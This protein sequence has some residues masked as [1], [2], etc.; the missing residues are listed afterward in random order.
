VARD[1]R[2]ALGRNERGPEPVTDEVALWYRRYH[3]MEY[4]IWDSEEEA[5]GIAAAMAVD[6]GG[7]P[8]GVQV[9]DGR[10]IP[11][12]EWEALWAARERRDRAWQERPAEKPRPKRK[13]KAPFDGGQIEI[14][15]SEPLWLGTP[16]TD[17]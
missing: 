16:V 2:A 14:E 7:V 5:A 13:I 4:A 9:Q 6:G 15:A 10:T 17:L 12:T 11:A 1:P 8:A 3:S